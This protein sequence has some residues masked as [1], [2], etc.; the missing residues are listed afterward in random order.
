MIGTSTNYAGMVF[1]FMAKH[2]QPCM[3]SPSLVPEE[4]SSFRIRLIE[5]EVEELRLAVNSKDLVEISDAIA[6]ILY[7]V[8]GA[9][10][11][12]GIPI[13]SIFEEVHRSNMSKEMIK[14]VGNEMKV[15]KGVTYSAPRLK[16]IIDQCIR[17]IEEN[18]KETKS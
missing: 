8:F 12:W 6:D 7:V 18:Y 4:L 13:D 11:T 5:E 1:K 9:A 16:P 3:R 10:V 15:G 14:V 17:M 2:G